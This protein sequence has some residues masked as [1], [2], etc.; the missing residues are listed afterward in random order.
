MGAECCVT[1]GQQ[2]QLKK[3]GKAKMEEMGS[4]WDDVAR[5]TMDQLKSHRTK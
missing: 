3:V 5:K 2:G 4:V 1:P